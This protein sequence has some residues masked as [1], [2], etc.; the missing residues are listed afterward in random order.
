MEGN[1]RGLKQ[2]DTL[3]GAASFPLLCVDTTDMAEC[4][5]ILAFDYYLKGGVK[6]VHLLYPDPTG[7]SPGSILIARCLA[8]QV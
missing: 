1:G 6:I 8:T 5:T 4:A 2:G 7:E 3:D